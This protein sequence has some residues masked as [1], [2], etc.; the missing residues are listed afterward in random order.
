MHKQATAIIEHPFISFVHR[1]STSLATQHALAQLENHHGLNSV[2]PLFCIWYADNHSKR[3]SQKQT[4][5]LI[6]TATHWHERVLQLLTHATQ[7]INQLKPALSQQLR[8]NFQQTL[9]DAESYGQIMLVNS[10]QAP[11]HAARS[12]RQI[13]TDACSNLATLCKLLQIR[14]D[15]K[16]CEAISLILIT[17]FPEFSYDKADHL[18]KKL[19]YKICADKETGDA[20]LKLRW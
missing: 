1:I 10:I 13:V 14:L 9:Q 3:L 2:L 4:K 16:D 20:Q 12:L 7:Q 11:D 19:L 18:C 5:E 8:E 6:A 15:A 17:A